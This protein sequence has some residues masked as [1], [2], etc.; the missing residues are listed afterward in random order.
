MSNATE[1][2]VSELSNPP[3]DSREINFFQ[4]LGVL[5]ENLTL[6]PLARGEKSFEASKVG[7]KIFK[8]N[9]VGNSVCKALFGA[10]PYRDIEVAITP[11]GLTIVTLNF[12][13][14]TDEKASVMLYKTVDSFQRILYVADGKFRNKT[15]LKLKEVDIDLNDCLGLVKT[16]EAIAKQKGLTKQ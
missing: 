13:G 14:F 12:G 15:R 1:R 11:S 2:R 6:R 10:K 3:I 7:V 9:G 16:I 4:T 8:E 5:F